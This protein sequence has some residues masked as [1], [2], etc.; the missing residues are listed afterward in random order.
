MWTVGLFIVETGER[1]TKLGHEVLAALGRWAAGRG[2]HRLRV[3]VPEGA[4]TFWYEAGFSPADPDEDEDARE[5]GLVA[6]ELTLPDA[7]G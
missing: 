3:G 4:E 5:E 7:A 6:M 1:G 2:A